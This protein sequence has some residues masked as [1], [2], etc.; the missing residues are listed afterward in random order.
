M[1]K[2]TLVTL[3][4]ALLMPVLSGCNTTEGLGRD[5]SKAGDAI[6]SAADETSQKINKNNQAPIHKKSSYKLR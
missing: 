5:I 6:S 2:L 3:T 1:K 4:C